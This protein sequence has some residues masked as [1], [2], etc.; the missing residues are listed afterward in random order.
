MNIYKR[1]FE[2]IDGVEREFVVIDI[3]DFNNYMFLTQTSF[4][5]LQTKKEQLLK[6]EERQQE[7][8]NKII[9]KMK[10]KDRREEE[11]EDKYK[12]SIETKIMI[13]RHHNEAIK[14]LKEDLKQ[15]YKEVFNSNPDAKIKKCDFCQNYKVYPTH[16]LNDDGKKY[17]R[18]YNKDNQTAKASCCVDCFLDVEQKKEERKQECSVYC[19]TC[20]SSYIAFGDIAILK[21]KNSIKHKKNLNK[22]EFEKDKTSIKL[23]LLS[24]KELNIICSKSLTAEGAYIINNYS[25][26]K[27]E[28]L[29]K[30]MYEHYDK[31]TF[32]FY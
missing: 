25:K 9:E 19:K 12:K 2:V 26:T 3:D 15:D 31:L 21:H 29:I 30:K 1:V 24:V 13:N 18:D 28:E 7:A 6:R 32:D 8:E 10:E 20:K 17:I 27:K 11:R 5:K 4:T 16:Y 23:E 22:K 14:K